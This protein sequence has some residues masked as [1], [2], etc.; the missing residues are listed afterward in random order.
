MTIDQHDT[1]LHDAGLPDVESGALRQSLIERA[2]PP[3]RRPDDGRLIELLDAHDRAVVRRRRLVGSGAFF[4][5]VLVGASAA[6]LAW[7]GQS[8]P[9]VPVRPATPVAP[10]DEPSSS[11]APTTSILAVASA[12]TNATTNGIAN[13]TTDANANANATADSTAPGI[14]PAAPASVVVGTVSRATG[15]DPT[16]PPNDENND[17]SSI[18]TISTEP[19]HPVLTQGSVAPTVTASVP[20]GSTPRSSIPPTIVGTPRPTVKLPPGPADTA[21]INDQ[22]TISYN[23]PHG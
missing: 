7:H 23:P 3:P 15:A 10:T 22:P 14:T 18:A 19:G 6:A 9:T 8:D 2:G 4:A 20:D 11:A 21:P 12:T 17:A 13:A 5:L 1:G 16:T